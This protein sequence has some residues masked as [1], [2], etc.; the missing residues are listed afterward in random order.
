MEFKA[1]F[2][3]PEKSNI[4]YYSNK[5][6]FYKAGYGMP[7]CTA[8]TSGRWMEINGMSNYLPI[9]GNAYEWFPEAIKK[10]IKTGNIPKL[11]AVACWHRQDGKTGHVAVVEKILP[12]LDIVV[13]NSAWKGRAFYTNIKR[14]ADGYDFRSGLFKYIFDGFIYP[15]IEYIDKPRAYRVDGNLYLRITAGKD[16]KAIKVMKKDSLFEA[17]GYFQ[18]INGTLWLHGIQDNISG[19]CSSKYLTEVY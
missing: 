18:V 5:N 2:T 1:R 13:S 4:L 14:Y 16:S 3:E 15:D 12:A 9:Y 7:N 17:D 6:R 19:W 8:Y 10:G 11:G